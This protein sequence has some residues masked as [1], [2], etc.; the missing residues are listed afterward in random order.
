VVA[1][2]RSISGGEPGFKVLL[3]HPL[4]SNF[5]P[6]TRKFVVLRISDFGLRTRYAGLVRRRKT[7]LRQRIRDLDNDLDPVPNL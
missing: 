3:Q 4:F 7:L 6:Q 1:R 2:N 5:T